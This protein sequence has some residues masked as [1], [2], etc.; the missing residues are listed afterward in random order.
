MPNMSNAIAKARSGR[1]IVLGLALAAL[2]SSCNEYQNALKSTDVNEKYKL[3]ERLYG[4]EDYKR[5]RRLFEQIAPKFV[6][7]AQG[8]RVLFFLADTQYKMGDHYFSGYQY[9][10]FLKSYPK[11][12]RAEEAAFY[13]AKS[14]YLLSPRYSLD[15]TDTDKALSKLQTF[16]N[17]YPE[18]EFFEEANQMASDLTVKKQRK[19]FEI[20]KQFEK[21]GE[22]NFPV[23][24]SAIATLDNFIVENP[25]S[26][27]REDAFFHRMKAAAVLALNSTPGRKKERLEDAIAHY[28]ALKRSY[29]ESTYMK[30]ADDLSERLNDE[31][32][33]FETPLAK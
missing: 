14:Y 21:L 9:E 8:E 27:Y 23:L 33:V 31:L 16:I 28:N 30:T 29:P 7:R 17:A 12:E 20:G 5:S 11:S 19:Q 6:G 18:S 32:K 2:L 13:G 1:G 24:I 25:G 3:A 26:P 4:E 15:Q 22:F 10:R